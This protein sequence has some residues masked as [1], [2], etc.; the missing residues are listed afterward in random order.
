MTTP[1]TTTAA[2]ELLRASAADEWALISPSVYESGRIVSDAPWLAGHQARLRYLCAEQAA[3]GGWGI[4]GFRLVATLS[5]TE[6]LLTAARRRAA[7]D[8]AV[9]HEEVVRAAARGVEALRRW[10][11]GPPEPLPD[12]VA[13]ELVVPRL[14]DLVNQHLADHEAEPE[15]YL[16]ASVRRSV[17]TPPPGTD[18]DLL[19]RVRAA[20]AAGRP[21]PPKLWHS[22]EILT[23]GRPRDALVRPV[24]GSVG[25]SPAATAAWLGLPPDL[26]HPC[27]RYLHTVQERG[28]GTLP[29]GAPMPYFERSW[30][31]N[32]FAG[33]GVPHVVPDALLDSLEGSLG[34]QGAPA[35]HGLPVDADDTAAVLLALESHGRGRPLDPL[36]AY[37]DGERFFTYP[38]ERTASPSANAHALDALAYRAARHPEERGRLSGPIRATARWLVGAQ[39]PDGSWHD[40]WHGSPYYAT[41]TCAKALAAHGGDRARP[42]VDRAVDWMLATRQGDRWG[43]GTGTVEET[44]YAAWTLL[45]A[46]G[47][48]DR[49]GDAG[50]G[51][52]EDALA[53]AE[54][55]LATGRVT[56][57][58]P[59]LWIGKDVYTPVRI[60]QATCL[61]A[62]HS[63]R[64]RPRGG[65]GGH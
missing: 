48:T 42:A 64:Q 3:D 34:E 4:A 35:G 20:T 24:H 10:L 41:A 2:D 18:P 57:S 44:A 14:V 11:G 36:L 13:I 21:I 7:V 51:H 12:L 28:A 22:W 29:V 25:C 5:A 47:G 43:H 17:L 52:V 15:P 1:V 49:A 45:L 58:S 33:H 46:A 53:A 40:K 16:P 30:I 19:A 56:A 23:P 65:N 6:A 62:L 9:P 32:I 27:A 39:N 55:T 31:L 61:A 8:L 26:G 63:L 37:F 60:V 59:P 54:R 50:A 38:E